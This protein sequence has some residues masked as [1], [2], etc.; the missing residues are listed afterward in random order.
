MTTSGVIIG[1]GSIT[2]RTATSPTGGESD[3]TTMSGTVTIG[4]ITTAITGE[5]TITTTSTA[6]TR[7][8]FFA[9]ASCVIPDSVATPVTST[10]TTVPRKG[11]TTSDHGRTAFPTVTNRDR[12]QGETTTIRP[13]DSPTATTGT[14][15]R[16]PGIPIFPIGII[17]LDLQ[18]EP[19]ATLPGAGATRLHTARPGADR[20]PAVTRQE[21]EASPPP[22]RPGGGMADPAV[23]LRDTQFEN[24][25]I[26]NIRMGV[27]RP[28]FAF[29]W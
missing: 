18:R 28:P 10:G 7:R 9:E 29:S 6:A 25:E 11:I 16:H 15:G 5:G 2:I 21:E 17:P 12:R 8:P 4:A 13:P 14:K 27:C 26:H 3:S 24:A 19:A 22:V 1:S 23:H 20:D